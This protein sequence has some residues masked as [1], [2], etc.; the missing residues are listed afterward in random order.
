[1]ACSTRKAQSAFLLKIVARS[2]GRCASLLRVLI[3]IVSAA[4]ATVFV[5]RRRGPTMLWELFIVE[6][7]NGETDDVGF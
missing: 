5:W 2:V 1:M 6:H 3:V 4:P 7:L